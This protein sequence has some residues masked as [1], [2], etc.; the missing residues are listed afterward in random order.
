MND[1]EREI[2]AGQMPTNDIEAARRVIHLVS[3]TEGNRGI[4]V[5][6]KV[7]V[8]LALYTVHKSLQEDGA[9]VAATYLYVLMRNF[10]ARAKI[11]IESL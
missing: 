1:L 2:L 10:C 9:I 7:E 11:H 6:S 8:A 4:H 5:S 3:G